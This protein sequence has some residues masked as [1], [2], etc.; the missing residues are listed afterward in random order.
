MGVDEDAAADEPRIIHEFPRPSSTLLRPSLSEPLPTS[1]DLKLS[2]LWE[3]HYGSYPWPSARV[4]CW[5]IWG[6]RWTYFASGM[7]DVLELGSGVGSCGLLVALINRHIEQWLE[8]RGRLDRSKTGNSWTVVLTDLAEPA[9]VLKN[10]RASADANGFN[11]TDSPVS[12]MPLKW[13]KEL[14]WPSSSTPFK[15][16]LILAADT[17]YD[18]PQF[19]DLLYTIAHTLKHHAKPDCV[20]LAAYQERSSKRDISVLLETYGLEGRVLDSRFGDDGIAWLEW[21]QVWKAREDNHGSGNE[22]SSDE[23]DSNESVGSVELGNT[24][25]FSSIHLI[26]LRLR[27][28][29]SI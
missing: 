6:N 21:Q 25:V 10:L 4:L 7:L 20:V 28:S 19:P 16:D 22:T 13:G 3:A 14:T 24:G 5:H 9:H 18:P 29:R 15:F 23:S 27:E 26:Q 17:F 12:I 8:A 11:V 1:L 2:T